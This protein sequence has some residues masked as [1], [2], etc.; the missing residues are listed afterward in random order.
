MHGAQ[1]EKHFLRQGTN[2]AG[3]GGTML[4]GKEKN[5]IR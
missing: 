3:K 2:V 4:Q 1:Y 5:T